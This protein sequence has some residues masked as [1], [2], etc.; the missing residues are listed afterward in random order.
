[1][2][3]VARGRDLLTGTDGAVSELDAVTIRLRARYLE[4]SIL[5]ISSEPELIDIENLVGTDPIVGLRRA[6]NELIPAERASHSVRYRLLAD[7]PGAL[8]A[9]GRAL[10]MADLP[11]TMG[12][13]GSPP[14]DICA[15]WAAGG[16][17]V[18]G[19]TN[20][21]PPLNVGPVAS[22]VAPADDPRA[23]HATEPLPPHGT[24]RRRR[25][26]VWG[27]DGTFRVEAFFR[28]SHVDHAGVETV[29]H[30]YTVTAAV[31]PA[32]ERFV[33]CRAEPGQLPYAECPSA[34]ASATRLE[35]M[36][37]SEVARTIQESFVGPTTCT[38]LND[39]F[40][41]MADLGALLPQLRA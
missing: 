22:S 14:V 33:W 8:L 37:V 32:D 10:R 6:V 30:E 21:G 38:H 18:V 9:S 3:V 7:L 1:M 39:T 4:R 40:R 26:E 12:R 31:D 35:G 13:R 5:S 15:G 29:V 20:A 28:D 25:T 36:A 19:F 24:R 2:T 41:A 23:W 17:V 27:E 11:I 34:T 16:T